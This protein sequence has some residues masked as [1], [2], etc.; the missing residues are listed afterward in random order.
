MLAPGENRHPDAFSS[1]SEASFGTQPDE[2]RTV[3]LGEPSAEAL[4][5]QEPLPWGP[6]IE[7]SRNLYPLPLFPGTRNTIGNWDWTKNEEVDFK[8]SVIF[9]VSPDFVRGMGVKTV[10]RAAD[11]LWEDRSR[12]TVKHW[13]NKDSARGAYVLG[14]FPAADDVELVESAFKD[15]DM[16]LLPPIVA[17]EG[18]SSESSTSIQLIIGGGIKRKGKSPT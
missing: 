15:A 18:S 5:V 7:D 4:I 14:R 16:T 6:D 2:D 13:L 12:R 1:A 11:L 17:F 10:E 9:W 8:K 3:S